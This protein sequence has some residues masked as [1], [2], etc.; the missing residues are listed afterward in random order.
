MRKRL[1]PA[2]SVVDALGG[3][4]KVASVLGLCRS[5]VHQWMQPK[6]ASE[7]DGFIPAKHQRALLE[8]AEREGIPLTAEMLIL[9]PK[10]RSKRGR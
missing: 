7:D 3:P 10:S 4:T 8:Y 2:K 1:E 6:D 9:G 5:A